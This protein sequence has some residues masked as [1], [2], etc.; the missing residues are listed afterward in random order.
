MLLV[1]EIGL[2]IAAW[3]RGWKWWSLIPLGGGV[4]LGFLIGLAIGFAGGSE[5]TADAVG[6]VLD[7]IIMVV[8]V[9]MIVKKR[10]KIETE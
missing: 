2:T 9:G 8:L 3:L 5:E 7:I 4:A 1:V 6:L 10:K